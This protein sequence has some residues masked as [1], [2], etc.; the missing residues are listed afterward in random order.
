M[1]SE[2]YNPV[3]SLGPLFKYAVAILVVGLAVRLVLGT[4]LTYTYDVHSWALIIS[5]IESGNGLYGI[6]GYNY[7]PPWGY[8][9]GLISVV[10]EFFGID[11][12]GERVT[13]AFPVED[14]SPFFSAYVTSIGFNLM[15]KISIFIAEILVGYLIY[16]IIRDMTGDK[17]K[18]LIGFGLWYLCPFVITVS[19][20][21]GMFDALPVMITLLCVIFVMKEKYWLGG[22]MMGVAALMK[23]FPA[24]LIFV[25][26]GYILAKH[27]GDGTGPRHVV[28]AAVGVVVIAAVMLAPDIIQGNLADCFSFITSRATSDVGSGL[29]DVERYITVAAY[30]L[31]LLASVVMG[32]Y[33]NRSGKEGLDRRLLSVLMLNTAVLFLYPATPQYILLL[34]PFLA[35]QIVLTDRRYLAPLGVLMVGTTMFSIYCWAADLMSIGAFTDIVGMDAVMGLVNAFGSPLIGGL[36]GFDVLYYTGSVIQYI[37]VAMVAITYIKRDWLLKRGGPLGE[38][39]IN[40]V[41]SMT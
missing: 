33:M 18:A 39:G 19:S 35:I 14:M 21:G 40:Y 22:V 32:L 24:F 15:I 2:T 36:T 10:G 16:W 5:N 4:V 31:L 7:A 27:R 38:D 28:E 25:L 6:N 20:V 12:F 17:K 9:L 34:M 3:R 11:F 26:I 30:V 41:E 1:F 29:G 37:G 13:D 23:M 8:V